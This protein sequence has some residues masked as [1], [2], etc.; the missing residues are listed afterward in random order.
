MAKIRD[1]NVLRLLEKIREHYRANISNCFLRPFV[2]QF[3]LDKNTWEQLEILTEKS[4]MFTFEGFHFD[5]LYRQVAAA[6]RFIEV[7]RHEVPS[8]KKKLSTVSTERDK[9]FRTMAINNF[10]SNLKIFADLVNELYITL[11]GL[12]KENAKNSRPVFAQMPEL[13]NVGRQLVG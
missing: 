4:E 13:A 10:G 5:E 9:I 12:D 7:S 1:S 2:L 8:L 11:A 6:A 3:P